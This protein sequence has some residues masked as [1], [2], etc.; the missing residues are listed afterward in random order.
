MTFLPRQHT[1]IVMRPRGGLNV[2]EITRYEVNCAILAAARVS[3]KEGIHDIICPNIQPNI[4]VVS[5]PS[6]QPLGCQNSQHQISA[7]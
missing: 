6:R 5:T 4:I 7:Y 2:A 1:K 3:T